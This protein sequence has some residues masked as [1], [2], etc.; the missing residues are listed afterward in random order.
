MKRIR[1]YLLIA[2]YSIFAITIPF[3]PADAAGNSPA[4]AASGISVG[5]G[6]NDV[7]V[8]PDTNMAVVTIQDGLSIVDLGSQGVIADVAVSGARSVTIDRGL[9]VAL[10]TGDHNAVSIIDLGSLTVTSKTAFDHE[11]DGIAVNSSNHTAVILS[12]DS[13]G[14]G[15]SAIIWDIRSQTTVASVPIKSASKAVAVDPELNLAVI[16]GEKNITVIDLTANQVIQQLTSGVN[17][18]AVSIN[19]ETHIAAIAQ[20]GNDTLGVLSL[21]D[22]SIVAIPVSKHPQYVAVNRLDNRALVI[23]VPNESASGKKGGAVLQLVD[24]NTDSIV[25]N[26]S[27]NQLPEGV[28]VN[29]FTNVAGVID[30]QT[31]SLNLIQLPN[32]APAVTS[33]SPDTLTRGGSKQSMAI[34]GSQFIQ[35]STAV[36]KTSAA[37]YPVTPI[38]TD[39]HNIQ[40]T[41]PDAILAA[42]GSW[43]VI[44]TN[45]PPDGGS[46][47][48]TGLDVINPVPAISV[49]S[50]PTVMAGTPSLQL[51]I[52]GSGF[53]NDTRFFVNDEPGDFTWDSAQQA[54]LNLSASDMEFGRYLDIKAYNAAPGGGYSQ[55]ARF[56]VLNPVP[57]LSGISPDK[58]LINTPLTFDI[59]GNGFVTTSDVQFNGQSMPF[60]YQG[61]TGIQVSIPAGM[62]PSAGSYPVEVVNPA[63]G[64]G[65]SNVLSLTVDNPLP[66]LSALEPSTIS[67]NAE[68]TIRLTG[69]G[70]VTGSAATVDGGSVVTTVVDS[71][72]LSIII[73]ASLATAGGHNVTITNPPPGGGVSD[74]VVLTVKSPLPPDPATV[75][76]S[77]DTTVATTMLAATQFLYTGSNP[78]QN[79]VAAGTIEVTRVAV[80]KGNV[81]TRD[82]SPLPGVSITILGHSEF[83]STLS[84]ADG[85]FDMAV[86]GGEI[87]TVSYAKSGYLP[88]QRQVNVPWQDYAKTSDVVMIQADSAVNPIDLSS[89]AAIQVARGNP[90]S[91][92][93]GMRQATLL[94]DQ[95]TAATMRF[96]DGS[97]QPISKMTVRA[98]EFTVG[99]NGPE[100][101]PGPLPGNIAYTYA[102]DYSVDE[103][104]AAG[105]ESVQFSQPVISYTDNFLNFDVGTVVPSAYYDQ[106]MGVWV[107][108]QNGLVV[109]ILSITS[110]MADLDIDGSGTPASA[111]ALASLGVTDAELQQLAAM[112]QPGQSLWRVPITHFSF[113]DFNWGI[114][115]P[116]DAVGPG[117]PPPDIATTNDPGPSCSI[118]CVIEVQNQTVGEIVSITGTPLSLNYRSSRMPGRQA[119]YKINIPLSG[120]SVPS[121]LQRIDLN[122]DIAGQTFTQSFPPL[123]GQS[124]SFHWN[125]LDAYGRPVQGSQP[126]T[127]SIGYV[128]NDG[129]SQLS[130][131]PGVSYDS[132]FGHFSYFGTPASGDYSRRQITLWQVN[133]NTV[134]SPST[135][136]HWNAQAEGFGG[137]TLSVQ[138]AYDPVG[139]VLYLGNGGERIVNAM[140]NVIVTTAGDG[141]E[142]Y[143]G[144]GGAASQAS[145]RHPAGL[146]ADGAGNIYVADQMNN[147]IRKI[148]TNGIITTIAGDGQAGFS[149][150]GGQ[151]TQAELHNPAGLAADG[152]GNIYVA[153]QMNNRI[154]KI[155]TNGIITT[156]AGDGQ[157]GFSGDGGQAAQAE[158]NMPSAVATD[159]Y[160]NVYIADSNNNRVRKADPAGIIYTI[161]GDGQT[162]YSG[163]GSQAEH[164]SLYHPSGVAADS[165]G[166]IYIADQ[167]NNRIRKVDRG[168]V[169]STI[170]G[171]GKNCGLTGCQLGDGGQALQASLNGPTGVAVD[172][173]GDIF[174]ADTSV[175]RIRRVDPTGVIGTIAGNGVPYYSGDG[176]SAANA[177]LSLPAAVAVDAAGTVYIADTYNNRVRKVEADL[178]GVSAQNII[179]PSIDGK[180]LYVFDSSGR[181]LRTVNALTGDIIYSFTYDSGGYL[182]TVM[183]GYGNVTTI[184][185]DGSEN[186]TSITAPGGQKTTLGFDANGFLSNASDP[187]GDA[188]RMSYDAGGLLTSFTDPNGNIHKYGYDSMGL[189]ISDQDPA[190]GTQVLSRTNMSD[191]YTVS[192]TSAMGITRTFEIETSNTGIERKTNVSPQGGTDVI[193]TNPDG[194]STETAPDGTVTVI[195]KAP[196]P[197]LGMLAAVTGSKTITTPSGLQYSLTD[198]RTADLSDPADPFSF[199]TLTD[200][201]NINGRTYISTYDAES[202]TLTETTP[203]GRK[204]V[205]TLNSQGKVVSSQLWGLLPVNYG[206][207]S[208]GHLAEITQGTGADSRVYS[209]TYDS[210]DYLAAITD[211]LSEITGF[212]YDQAGRVTQEALPDGQV[213]DYSYDSN[214]NMTSITPPGRP[215]HNFDY[216]S[217]DLTKDYMPPSIGKVDTNTAYA[218]DLDRNLIEVDRPAGSGT[219]AMDL[220][221]NTS[222]TYDGFLITSITWSGAINGSVGFTYNNDFNIASET[223]D[224]GST[225]NFTYDKDALLVSS[226]P[227]GGNQGSDDFVIDR[228]LGNGF[229]TGT[230]LGGVS[231]AWTYDGFGETATYSAFYNGSPLMSDQY[232]YDKLG[233]ITQKTE[234]INGV[235]DTYT[236]AYDQAGRLTDVQ[237]DITPVSHYDYD[238]NGNRLSYTSGATKVSGTYDDQDRLLTYGN[239]S[240]TYTDNGELESRTGPDGTTSYNYDDFG[241]LTSVVKPDGT[242]IDYIIDGQNRRVGKEINGALVQ[243]FLYKDQLKPVA[244]LDGNGNIVSRFVYGTKDNVPDYMIKN[245]ETYRIISDN[246]G[247]PR[248]VVDVSTGQIIQQM[249]YD[250]F[251]NVTQDTNPGFQP[252]GY[253]GGLYDKD[254][255]LVRFGARD[256]DPMTGKWTAKDP[257][258]FAGGDTNLFGY[259]LQDPINRTDSLGLFNAK[260]CIEAMALAIKSSWEAS[261]DDFKNCQKDLEAGI[262][263]CKASCKCAADLVARH[264]TES[265]CE[266]ACIDE[267]SNEIRKC[268]SPPPPCGSGGGGA[269]GRW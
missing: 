192:L 245:G 187:A 44:V 52:F 101:M 4:S 171:N 137:W 159:S 157:A 73:P 261:E 260:G 256:Y 59:N 34:S 255:G 236:Y 99:S 126:F 64:G 251:G 252:F 206:Y 68:A 267:V 53:F 151:A 176:G 30:D 106:K 250:E 174:I 65:T 202:K 194:S 81:F 76:P 118:G 12:N 31:D 48:S 10:V 50:P 83:G 217:L 184:E 142:A 143:G 200:S 259:V 35:T 147:R 46:S 148:D 37:S 123:P 235:T 129:Y 84:R 214:S 154:R 90:V 144:D 188:A 82:G 3:N 63:P 24:L 178:P 41:V 179:I 20:E 2:F 14:G 185:R 165:A 111:Q 153:D 204:S 135:T 107:P 100:A 246:L 70:F 62:I 121:S 169:I 195:T 249:T 168:G 253:A 89:G 208:Q 15:N 242:E 219:P 239:Y 94:F 182:T 138:H 74:P 124:Y 166:D 5:N 149:G 183:D 116:I 58:T 38:F 160:G 110:G 213:I 54:T 211:P 112:Y 57:E 221:E 127:T 224:G 222:F 98:T 152:A 201:S 248:M 225:V 6:P 170:V 173:S 198:A 155:D 220:T 163:D 105:A 268:P 120:T 32:P 141:E 91:D 93:S 25:G 47:V 103:A 43:Q 140:N 22:W 7:A 131:P 266:R 60:T 226:Q 234:T 243:D 162:G 215:A 88:V 23:S 241:N 8:N 19:P 114:A 177:S 205:T 33:V 104:S 1:L 128:Y 263:T 36:I 269:G 75:A 122:V 132:L 203:M 172:G 96:A 13:A 117:Q 212:A 164:A 115:P 262:D 40:L 71:N 167:L 216:T 45:P 254:T 191:G 28:A 79:G 87:L 9:N 161:A 51:D 39:N 193:T 11:I 17:Q 42:T 61:L 130:S 97:T 231:D 180:E 27:L 209:Y 136:G 102:V 145:L 16:V 210:Q 113:W 265:D 207:D 232:V 227:S 264:V 109:E 257:I 150:D 95:G 56:T 237:K 66:V 240:Y 72:D 86:N 258:R 197:R 223:V 238:L 199:K 21:L 247:S 186:I 230:I 139:H 189:L 233:R 244:E 125:G 49:L 108:S 29:N 190:G 26:Y 55:T 158:L 85:A 229:V 80:I 133:Q 77:L 119:E 228:D 92:D 181:H 69:S 175:S 146:A 134:T 67:P 156:I 218:Y 78:V 196:D 18:T